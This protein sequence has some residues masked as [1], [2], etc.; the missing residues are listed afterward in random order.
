MRRTWIW[1][2]AAMLGSGVSCCAQAY[3]RA[4]GDTVT[5]G[6]RYLER[7]ITV[8]DGV[9]GTAALLNKLSGRVYSLAGGEFE[10]RLIYERVGYEVG[11]E[12]PWTL[13]AR[14]FRVLGRAIENEPDGG[15]RVTFHLGLRPGE[16]R[17]PQLALDLVYAIKP[18]DFFTRQWL[19]LKTS[20]V[21]TY[22]IDSLAVLRDRLG[23]AHFT[24]GGFGQPLFTDDLFCGLEYPAG[25]NTAAAGV[26]SLA[27]VVGEDVP[28]E[29]YQTAPAVIG[30]AAAGEV[31]R[32]F[33]AY[34][35]RIR[36]APVRP[37]LL[38][39]TWY[40]LQATRMNHDN[41][42]AR[43][44]QLQAMLAGRYGLHLDS[45]VLDD[46]WDDYQ[47][48][49]K[50]D[51]QRFPGGF[52]DLVT[53]LHGMDSG[54]GLWFGP[55]GG[56]GNRRLR[57]ATA[58]REGMEIT[59]NGQFLCLAGRRYS[60]YFT[61]TVLAYQRQ[62]GINYFKLDG[63]PFGCNDPDHG[64]PVGLAS[65]EADMRVL[66]GLLRALRRQ[67]PRVFLNITTSIWLSPWW[68]QYA[69]TVWMG[70]E[71]SGYLPTVPTL[72][73]RQSAISYRDSVLYDDFVRH[74]LQFPMS[75]LMTHGIIQGQFNMLGGKNE[76]LAQWDDEVVHYFS[77]GN[78]MVELYITPALL[79]PA[80]WSALAGGI[81]WAEANAHP[82]LDN[83]TFVLGD[84]ARREPYGFV[85]AGAAKTIVTLRNP[86][87]AP[88]SVHLKLDE[89]DGFLPTPA[90]LSAEVVYPYR[91]ALDR[92]LHFGDTLDA[93]LG[94]YEERVIV[95]EPA[96]N[97]ELR[98]AGARYAVAAAGGNTATLTV[99][100]PAGTAPT[101]RWAG[102][103]A[104]RLDGKP[105][106]LTTTAG[107]ATTV[108]PF[109]PRHRGRTAPDEPSFTAPTLDLAPQTSG[110]RLAHWAVDLAVPGDF[111]G[112]QLAL[113]VEPP[114]ETKGVAAQASDNG[115]PVSPR[116]ENGGH[117]QW[118]W[119][120][121]PLAAGR[122]ALQLNLSLPAAAGGEAWHLSAWL[123][124]RRA[125][126]ARQL[127]VTLAKGVAAPAPDLLPARSNEA[128]EQ[129]LLMDRVVQ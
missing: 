26:V 108:V 9:A 64:H 65:R 61:D 6:N 81:R 85:H 15:R 51:P 57:L 71:D 93:D 92:V 91:R 18:E 32:Q 69:D 122:H 17:R 83:A 11:G 22:F 101:L 38:Y 68:L 63:I 114:S 14:D 31:H 40:D 39:N 50:I 36:A 29:G 73:P 46:A 104:A 113:L 105:L 120:T 42:L 98:I 25:S 56:Y 103:A 67:D 55:I 80:E 76:P 23:V 60:R 4:E 44:A 47:N 1:V 109:G 118:V 79:T 82:L 115:R 95:L 90:A 7:T 111:A 13:T 45:F 58:R 12:N 99:Y 86:F 88:R 54:L 126:V 87:A 112:S 53:A 78:M 102:A 2:L 21:G 75:S 24:L 49:W 127:E 70:G 59:S 41:T 35:R 27:R 43:V 52:G 89:A 10:L 116:L 74:Q 16:R 8:R 33:M 107:E 128:R 96:G 123:L 77:V 3:A 20:G 62:Y 72:E 124:G 106:A 97:R 48:L 66:I 19:R 100:A 117:G 121:L 84:P 94:A 119:V 129:W 34:V 125:L 110:G 5:L 30:V 37:Y 28:P